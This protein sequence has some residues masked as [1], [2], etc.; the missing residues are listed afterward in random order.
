MFLRFVQAILW[1]LSTGLSA[2][3]ALRWWSGDRFM[4]VRLL[5]YLM[6]WMLL[7]LVAG[8][9][10]AAATHQRWLAGALLVPTA[11]IAALYAPLY[12]P[13]S[14]QI[15]E[16]GYPLKLMSYNV[17]YYNTQVD[18]MS[19]VV[20]E[21]KPDILL[22]Q[23]VRPDIFPRLVDSLRRLHPGETMHADYDRRTYQGIVSRYPL[24]EVEYMPRLGQS[25][26]A[27][28]H[29]PAGPIVVYNV[30]P[31]RRGGWERRHGEIEKLLKERV[32]RERGAVIVGGDFNTTEGTQMYRM[33]GHHF[34]NAHEAAGRGLGFT[35]PADDFKLFGRI[36]KAPPL[37]RIDHLFV[38]DHFAVRSAATLR[39][40]G[41]SDHRPVVAEVVLKIP[42]APRSLSPPAERKDPP[43]P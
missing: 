25:Q 20:R 22:L 3:L 34:E 19:R 37:V 38:S 24:S 35:F 28:V 31:L 13:R 4:A 10:A 8:F 32:L 27:L 43:R 2:S 9:I 41:G 16:G 36:W 33:I 14:T 39:D 23:E 21:Q 5:N 11:I 7:P 26:R 29:T 12:L 15:P 18:E 17:W 6:P 1:L 40:S 42:T 30:H